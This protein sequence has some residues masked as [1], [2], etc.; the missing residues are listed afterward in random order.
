M[1]STVQQLNRIYRRIYWRLSVA[2]PILCVVVLAAGLSLLAAN[3]PKVATW[4]SDSAQAEFVG[5]NP[6]ASPETVRLALPDEPVRQA[7]AN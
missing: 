7:K 4:I 6:L 1:P 5:A 2:F 3:N